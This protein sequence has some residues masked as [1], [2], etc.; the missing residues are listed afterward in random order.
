MNKAIAILSSL[1]ILS[2][3]GGGGGGSS[4]GSVNPGNGSGGNPVPANNAPVLSPISSFSMDENTTTTI[5]LVASDADGDALTFEASSDG[6]ITTVVSGDKLEITTAEVE[7]NS[8]VIVSVNVS[9]GNGGSDSQ[10]FTVT[11]NNIIINTPPSVV[12]SVEQLELLPQQQE[13]ITATLSDAE[14]DRAFST[15]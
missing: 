1:L 14:N 6:A 8:D 10:Q 4:T 3:C 9:D 12:L 5:T 7:A 11:V 2:A 15:S 13:I